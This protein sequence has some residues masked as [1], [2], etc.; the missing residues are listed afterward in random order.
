[1]PP[2]ATARVMTSTGS[3]I[4]QPVASEPATGTSASASPTRAVT[5]AIAPERLWSGANTP[6]A[7]MAATSAASVP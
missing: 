2:A 4:D 3:Q 7:T 1:M 5:T 6:I